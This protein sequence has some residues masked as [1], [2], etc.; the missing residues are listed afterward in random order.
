MYLSAFS[1]KVSLKVTNNGD[2]KATCNYLLIT[3]KE[4]FDDRSVF[5]SERQENLTWTNKDNKFFPKPLY[6]IKK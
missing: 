3:K 2:A 5:E 4:I 1:V 6:S